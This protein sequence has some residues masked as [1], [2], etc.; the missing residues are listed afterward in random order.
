MNC[1][2]LLALL[3]KTFSPFFGFKK[4]QALGFSWFAIRMVNI[5]YLLKNDSVIVCILCFIQLFWHVVSYPGDMVLLAC[6]LAIIE[7]CDKVGAMSVYGSFFTG[8]ILSQWSVWMLIADVLMMWNIKK[9][10]IDNI[11]S[12]S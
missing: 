5:L 8:Y 12:H 11:K 4:E 7:H 6:M 2:Y 3:T 1:A 9:I 10:F